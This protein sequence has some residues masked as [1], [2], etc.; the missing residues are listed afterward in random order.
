MT[1]NAT[2]LKL[3]KN[4]NKCGERPL[5]INHKKAAFYLIFKQKAAKSDKHYLEIS[6]ALIYKSP[7]ILPP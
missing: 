5:S 7:Q 2:P 4:Q 3:S 1:K 6:L